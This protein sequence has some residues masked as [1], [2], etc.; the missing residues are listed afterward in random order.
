MRSHMPHREPMSLETQS[1]PQGPQNEGAHSHTSGRSSI[2]GA[3][4]C[5]GDFQSKG[6]HSPAS[7]SP[8]LMGDTASSGGTQTWLKVVQCRG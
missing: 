1:C 8:H 3:I 4:P 5:L 2:M 6:R 7:E